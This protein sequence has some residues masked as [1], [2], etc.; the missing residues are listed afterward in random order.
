MARTYKAA[1][2]QFVR[3]GFDNE[4]RTATSWLRRGSQRFGA[5]GYVRAFFEDANRREKN[6]HR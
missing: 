1:Y 4:V 6:L 2:F 3:R 5:V